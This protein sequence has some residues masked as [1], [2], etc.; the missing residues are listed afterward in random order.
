MSFGSKMTAECLHHV[1]YL[2]EVFVDEMVSCVHRQWFLEVFLSPCRGFHDRIMP[3]YNAVLA[4]HADFW[5]HPLNKEMSPDSLNLL[6]FLCTVDN[7]IFKAILH[8]EALFWNCSTVFCRSLN[9]CPS[10]HLRDSA[11]LRCSFFKSQS[12]YWP[13]ANYPVQP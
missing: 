9:L 6:M 12:S 4:Y 10:L 8:G 11:S 3:H 2:R 5:L 7:G 13:V 1:L